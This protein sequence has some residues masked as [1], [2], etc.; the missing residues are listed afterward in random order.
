M[1]TISLSPISYATVTLTDAQVKALPTTGIQI[2]ASP[3]AGKHLLVVGVSLYLDWTADYTNI[4]PTAVISLN[5]GTTSNVAGGRLIEG[6][7]DV[8]RML[9]PG[10][11]ALGF[12]VQEYKALDADQAVNLGLNL[13]ATNGAAGDFT[14]GNAANTLKVQVWF[15][16]VTL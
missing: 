10:E 12:L 4:D 16:T 1:G 11:D 8:T 15:V 2:V 14:G 5:F 6:E 7:G 9:A 13:K 3:G